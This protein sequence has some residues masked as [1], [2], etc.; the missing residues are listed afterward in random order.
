MSVVG[1]D[2]KDGFHDNQLKNEERDEI[3]ESDD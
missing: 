3:S 1:V 2:E